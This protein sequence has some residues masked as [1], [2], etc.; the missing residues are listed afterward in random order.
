MEPLR[1]FHIDD[2]RACVRLV[3]LWLAELEDIEHVGMLRSAG[4]DLTPL[5]EASPDVVLL[6]TMGAAG[7]TA[8]ADAVRGA[9]PDA[10]LVLYSGHVGAM[11]DDALDVG[12]DAYLGKDD[13]EEH[14]IELLRGLRR[15]S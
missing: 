13:T 1:V 12:A 6:D 2:S 7:D 15:P 5:E 14:L 8:L 10:R 9:V 4:D 3:E 11:P